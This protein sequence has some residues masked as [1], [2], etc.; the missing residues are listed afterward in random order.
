MPRGKVNFETRRK[1]IDSGVNTA[2]SALFGG[3]TAICSVGETNDCTVR[4][5]ASAFDLTYD[6]AHKWL[7]TEFG[8][9]PRKGV[10]FMVLDKLAKNPN[11]YLVEEAYELQIH[12]VRDYVYET[13]YDGWSV[14][15]K[16]TNERR[17]FVRDRTVHQLLKELE[18]TNDNRTYIV[19]V[20]RHVFTIK[21]Q[22]IY[23]NTSD[24]FAMKKKVMALIRVSNV[25]K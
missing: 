3:A 21:N 17:D 11:G 7:E 1:Y 15:R 12:T 9:E 5:A 19:R 8:R 24:F 25:K 6:E 2:R 13:A 23:G 10:R 14:E 20:R 22:Q 16:R 18:R 4:A